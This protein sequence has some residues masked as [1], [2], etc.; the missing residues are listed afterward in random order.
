M[1]RFEGDFRRFKPDGS[2][3][4][5]L[6]AHQE[7]EVKKAPTVVGVQFSLATPEFYNP[8]EPLI[9][10]RLLPD[11]HKWAPGK[12]DLISAPDYVI[13]T[14]GYN[15]DEGLAQRAQDLHNTLRVPVQADPETYG[16]YRTVKTYTKEDVAGKPYSE[17]RDTIRRYGRVTLPQELPDE[18]WK[19]Y[20]WVN[21]EEMENMLEDEMLRGPH[22]VTIAREFFGQLRE[23]HEGRPL[24]PFILPTDAPQALIQYIKTNPLSSLFPNDTRLAGID[25]FHPYN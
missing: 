11:N 15:L 10:L 5:V 1:P 3:G 24:K 25:E 9:L 18:L 4:G 8:K 22:I 17:D 16:Y 23:L 20:N 12:M 19:E 13:G 7:G 14:H 21:L 6:P 2:Q